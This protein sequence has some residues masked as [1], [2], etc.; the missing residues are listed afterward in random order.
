MTFAVAVQIQLLNSSAPAEDEAPERT[1]ASARPVDAGAPPGPETPPVVTNRT[2]TAPTGAFVALGLGPTVLF[3]AAPSVAAG[4]RLFAE[5]D[6]RALSL[7][8]A[9]EVALPVKLQQSDGTG[10]TLSTFGATLAPCARVRRF[11]VCVLGALSRVQV[12]GLGVDDPRSPS[13]LAVK[14]GLRASFDQPL[15]RRF[16]LRLHADGLGTLTPGTVYL[17]DVPVFTTRTFGLALG[18]DT[19]VRF[20]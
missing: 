14:A 13:A 1:A 3:G 4:G 17:N 12:V 16:L 6:W 7:E 2:E 11:A 5:L 20:Q 10:F 19:V 8:L 18:I 9:G 15:S